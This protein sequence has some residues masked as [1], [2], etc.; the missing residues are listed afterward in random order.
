[1]WSKLVDTA[2]TVL[3]PRAE[4][5]GNGYSAFSWLFCWEGRL[6]ALLG[7]CWL[8]GLERRKPQAW[9]LGIWR[10]LVTTSRLQ[11]SVRGIIFCWLVTTCAASVDRSSCSQRARCPDKV[12]SDRTAKVVP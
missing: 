1:M 2:S 5:A 9:E 3:L 12:G 10:M 6:R 11:R 4:D 7:G 8:Q